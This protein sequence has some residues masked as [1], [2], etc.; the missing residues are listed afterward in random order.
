M[1][2]SRFFASIF[3]LK[4]IKRWGLKANSFEENVMEHS[5]QV[6]TIAHALALIHNN[7][8]GQIDVNKVAVVALYHDVA[9]VITGD[10]PSPIKYHSS[11]I[12]KAYQ[13]IEKEAE[14]T[15][16]QMLPQS[17]QAHYC[18]VM[19]HD[20]IPEEIHSIVKAADIISAYI[21]CQ[22]ELKAG[23]AEFDMAF[24]DIEQRLRNLN[25][26]AVDYFMS[27]F[28]DSYLLTLDELLAVH[29]SS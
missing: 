19:L 18:E 23:N 10:L 26:P 21:K 14:Q 2:K 7:Q 6:A 12:K 15:L 13:S 20:H 16:Y 25:M 9:E 3:C 29:E 24:K 22:A 8:G 1:L 27:V 28:N 5:W 17:I 4:W 11:H